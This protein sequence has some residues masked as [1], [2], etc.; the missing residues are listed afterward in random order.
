MGAPAL[1]D[2][3]A[4]TILDYV[5]ARMEADYNQIVEGGI[6]TDGGTTQGAGAGTAPNY[7]ADASATIAVI[8]GQKHEKAATA[9]IDSTAGA[10]VAWGATSGKALI[11]TT[12]FESGSGNDTPAWNT[13]MG[14]VAD[15]GDEVAPTDAEI[16]A[17]LGHA[18]WLRVSDS[19]LTRVAD[20]SIT[21]VPD[22]TVRDGIVNTYSGVST[23]ESA[24]RA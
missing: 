23:T 3:Q 5:N 16:T 7:D 9:D 10:A 11:A 14:D 21:L 18:N 22:H 13:V 4:Q 2:A 17:A 19:V 1:I 8:N 20:T 12:V 24:F 15:T 6:I